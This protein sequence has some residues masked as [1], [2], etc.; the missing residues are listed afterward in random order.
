WTVRVLARIRDAGFTFQFD[1]WVLLFLRRGRILFAQRRRRLAVVRG[2][3]VADDEPP[4]IGA[5]GVAGLAERLVEHDPGGRFL[6]LAVTR[7]VAGLGGITRV[8]LGAGRRDRRRLV[9]F[10][11]VFEGLA[12]LDIDEGALHQLRLGRGGRGE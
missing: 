4:A 3:I 9:H 12:G 5:A 6:R 7:P 10:E 1:K 8:F 2:G 11:R